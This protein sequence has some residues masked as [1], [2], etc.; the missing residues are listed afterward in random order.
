MAALEPVEIT[1]QPGPRVRLFCFPYA[2]SGASVFAAWHSHMPAE[3]EIS[4]V[5][6]PGRETRLREKLVT[7]LPELV[8]ILIEEVEVPDEPFAFFGH[9]MGAL[10]AFEMTLALRARHLREPIHLFVSGCRAP[11]MRER[12]ATLYQRPDARLTAELRHL[13]GTPEEVFQNPELLQILLPIF[14]ADLAL[15]ASYVCRGIAP[16]DCP[17]TAFGALDD[18]R[19][20]RR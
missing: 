14:R 8:R 9:S 18:P 3:I 13:G 11:H 17:I 10:V 5:Q 6:L 4:A 1:H 12:F 7:H 15:C 2:G 20:T 16:L 19:V